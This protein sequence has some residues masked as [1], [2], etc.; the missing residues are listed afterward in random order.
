MGEANH[1]I[2][3]LRRGFKIIEELRD[4]ESATVT[5]IAEM[6]DLPVSSVYNYVQ[7]L[8]DEN[9]IVSENGNYRLAAKWAHLGDQVK[10]QYPVYRE[11]H[12]PV[13]TLANETELTANLVVEEEGKGYYLMSEAGS[14]GLENYSFTRKEEYLHSTAAGKAILSQFSK[15]E[16][17]NW[18]RNHGLPQET[19]KTI[20]N[21]D[22]LYQEIN[23]SKEQGYTINK[24]E[25]TN[26]IWAIG[27]PIRNSNKCY[28]SLSLSGSI[29]QI[30]ENPDTSLIN[31]LKETARAIELKLS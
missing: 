30:K 23:K 25:N 6:I 10:E 22:E 18:V 9:Y 5:E 16:V 2:D 20:T 28:T 21:L 12:Q 24:G 15:E 7:T 13:K 14:Q 3:S 4:L 1:T 31:S 17:K 11:G 8:E 29:S 27:I 26:G 19:D